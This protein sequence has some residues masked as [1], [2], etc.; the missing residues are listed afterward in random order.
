MKLL[1]RYATSCALKI[2]KPF[3]YTKYFPIPFDKYI[4]IN[5]TSGMPAKNYDYFSEVTEIL[6]PFLDEAGIRILQLGGKDDSPVNHSY[7]LRGG[8]SI[9]QSAY[10]VS[11]AILLLC[12]DSCLAHIAGHFKI[13]LCEL[14]GSTSVTNHSPY[15]FAEDKTTFLQGDLRN[16][17][18]SFAREEADKVVNRILPELVAK[19]VLDILEIPNEIKR[20]SIYFGNQYNSLMLDV[21]PNCVLNS[22]IFPQV[23][24]NLRMDLNFNPDIMAA[25][26]QQRKYN[27]IINTPIN[28]EYFKAL[29][30]N[31]NA[32]V[33]DLD[34]EPNIQ[35]AEDI[36][37][38]GIPLS[39]YSLAKDKALLDLKLNFMDIG[40]IQVGQKNGA[41]LLEKFPQINE[42]TKYK[43]N[44]F[45]LSDNKIFL[46][47]ARWEQEKSIERYEDNVD[48]IDFD[49]TFLDYAENF[50]L[51]NE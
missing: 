34:K 46:N 48:V 20:Q 3:I 28:L 41:A 50:Y 2:G 31:I 44:K 42:N 9:Q 40:L 5:S 19:S 51:F 18:H 49:P 12:V 8:T 39:L 45:F 23:T 6:K 29:R 24:P 15:K 35:F 37:R 25:N 26:L 32:I 47:R 36:K 30:P 13:G 1:E 11:N 22:Q 16:Q 27:I 38:L 4:V 43:T 33:Y 14:F 21:I 7:D 17:K 10:L